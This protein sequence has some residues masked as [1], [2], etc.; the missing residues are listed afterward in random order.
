MTIKPVYALI[1]LAGL[2]LCGS[3][4]AG[5][6]HVPGH[7]AAI[8]DAVDAAVN[9][10]TVLVADGVYSGARNRDIDFLGKAIAVKSANG[11]GKTTIDCG[12]SSATPH[13]GFIFENGEGPTALLAGFTIVNGYAAVPG[14]YA[15]P[16]YG[17]GGGILCWQKSSPTIEDCVLRDC[18]AE[19]C[20]GGMMIYYA[21]SPSLKNCTFDNNQA[22]EKTFLGGMGGGISIYEK[23]NPEI[24]DCSFLNNSSE[25]GGGG[26]SITFQSS[27]TI[28]GCLVQDN[29]PG[30][31][32]RSGAPAHGDDCSPWIVGN[33][34]VGNTGTGIRC[35]P[36]SPVIENNFVMNN[37]GGSAGGIGVSGKNFTVRN[38]T[39][40]G[41]SGT[42]GGGLSI[43]PTAN[44]TGTV[45]RN[46]VFAN[47]AEWGGGIYLELLGSITI[48]QCVLV[49]N[50]ANLSGG[51]IYT[52]GDHTILNCTLFENSA[53]SAGGGIIAAFQA[54][55][56]IVNSIL[57]NDTPAEVHVGSYCTI[58]ISYSNIEGGWTGTG[59]ID[60]DPLFADA[61]EYDLHLRFDS[62]CRDSGDNSAPSLPSEDFEND[63][64]VALG[65]VDI[66]A[67]EYYYHLYHW[68]EVIPGQTIAIKTVGIPYFP[69]ALFAGSAL[70]DPP[71]NTRHGP[72]HLA[73]PPVWCGWV[74]SIPPEGILTVPV[75]VPA[76]WSP[77]SDHPLQALIGPWGNPWTRFTNPDV[78]QVE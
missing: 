28:S 24:V 20:G 42:Q 64:R 18:I 46:L 9:G 74:G 17:C 40:R 69:V 10:D 16:P 21:S 26:I 72:F 7:Y 29:G 51:G 19:N 11:S 48:S 35:G 47:S 2:A 5:T 14:P 56:S 41:N 36:K 71:Y 58:D 23:S 3:L 76:A 45:S 73:W 78:L 53:V 65:T 75:T 66:G 27:P 37:T 38:N 59:N 77:G 62:P 6:L 22:Q 68:G 31:G 55:P 61:A 70:H 30:G 43:T 39:I 60:E 1:V 49:K 54:E 34:V 57:W 63:P 4:S 13:R 52:K 8:Q 15:A 44:C 33:V 67:D 50:H 32:L 12:G 25:S